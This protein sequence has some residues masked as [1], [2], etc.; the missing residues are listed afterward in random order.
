MSVA[1][2]AAVKFVGLTSSNLLVSDLVVKSFQ[3]LM[4]HRNM[5][6]LGLKYPMKRF[7]FRLESPEAVF[8]HNS[9]FNNFYTT[10]NNYGV[11]SYREYLQ[12]NLV[13]T[14]K[15][16]IQYIPNGLN[17]GLICCKRDEKETN[18]H[19]LNSESKFG[20]W[21]S[22]SMLKLC[23]RQN[24]LEKN[25]NGVKVRIQAVITPRTTCVKY[26]QRFSGSNMNL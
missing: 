23:E 7:F 12:M 15:M 11:S 4:R 1:A 26:G 16:Y 8:L 2:H 19:P 20:Y 10:G 24:W 21:P 18:E 17:T 14:F 6:A 25:L 3:P 9:W 5:N 22:N 13:E